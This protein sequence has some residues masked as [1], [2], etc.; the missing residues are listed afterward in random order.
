[1]QPD[2]KLNLSRDTHSVSTVP[3]TLTE[4]SPT[5]LGCRGKIKCSNRKDP[6]HPASLEKHHYHLDL[7]SWVCSWALG[8][9][10]LTGSPSPAASYHLPGP[11]ESLGC[12]LVNPDEPRTSQSKTSPCSPLQKATPAPAASHPLNFLHCRYKAETPL[13]TCKVPT[14][15]LVLDAAQ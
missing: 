8:S 12:R 9:A 13:V 14:H 7:P 11:E 4:V 5:A 15:P 1:M 3:E 6:R 10:W 2:N